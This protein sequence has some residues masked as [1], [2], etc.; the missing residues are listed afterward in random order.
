MLTSDWVRFHHPKKPSTCVVYN[1]DTVQAMCGNKDQS[2]TQHTQSGNR[3]PFFS[4]KHIKLFFAQ[5]GKDLYSVNV[6]NNLGSCADC[7]VHSRYRC[8]AAQQVLNTTLYAGRWINIGSTSLPPKK[9]PQT[10]HQPA[11][12][13][14]CSGRCQRRDGKRRWRAD[15]WQAWRACLG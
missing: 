6:L 8:K 3:I 1:L 5:R 9:L 15:H 7:R 12:L 10:L 14:S 11:S 4:S 2:W 13:V